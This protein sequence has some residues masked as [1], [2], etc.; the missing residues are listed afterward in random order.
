MLIGFRTTRSP[1]Y[2]IRKLHQSCASWN[3]EKFLVNCDPIH[4][5]LAELYRELQLNVTICLRD[6]VHRL[7]HRIARSKDITVRLTSNLQQQMYTNGKT[8]DGDVILNHLQDVST[9]VS[10][11]TCNPDAY[12]VLDS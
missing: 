6:H 7:V 3:E 2:R 4:R 9:S 1:K 11:T 10:S 5:Q 12:Y 8:D